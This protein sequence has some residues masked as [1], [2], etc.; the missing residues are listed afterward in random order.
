M[1]CHDVSSE[2]Q[3]LLDNREHWAAELA[4]NL[5]ALPQALRGFVERPSSDTALLQGLAACFSGSTAAPAA[6]NL[7]GEAPAPTAAPAANV[8]SSPK[9]RGDGVRLFE[10]HGSDVRVRYRRRITNTRGM[11]CPYHCVEDTN[12]TAPT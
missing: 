5:T 4:K 6:E 9:A 11:Q 1:S 8:A 7:F 3:V 12:M 2:A 10:K